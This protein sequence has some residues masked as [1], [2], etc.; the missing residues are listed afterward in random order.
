MYNRGTLSGIVKTKILLNF[1][2]H[3]FG[4]SLRDP[5]YECMMFQEPLTVIYIEVKNFNE[6]FAIRCNPRRAYVEQDFSNKFVFTFSA[7]AF[8]GIGNH[9]EQL[10]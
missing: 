3:C 6:T 5:D 8:S 10:S 1:K 7:H 9:G 4:P 2:L